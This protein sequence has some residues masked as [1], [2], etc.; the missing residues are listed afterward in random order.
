MPQTKIIMFEVILF[1]VFP[2]RDTDVYFSAQFRAKCL[3]KCKPRP[4]VFDNIASEYKKRLKGLVHLKQ[5][6]WAVY[7]PTNELEEKT[8]NMMHKET[9]EAEFVRAFSALKGLLLSIAFTPNALCKVIVI[10]F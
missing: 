1:H 2:Q 8:V 10:V 5:N 3:S 6:T 4:Q 7:N 9:T